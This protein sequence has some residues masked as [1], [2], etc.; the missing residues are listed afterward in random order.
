MQ[1]TLCLLAALAFTA[2]GV[3]MKYADGLRHLPA[4][5]AYLALFVAGAA[6]QSYA[7]RGAELGGT[8]ILV[9][10]AEALFAFGFGMFF[11]GEAVTVAKAAAMVLIVSGIAL[12]RIR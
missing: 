6:C 4:S 9:L 8:Y 11:F 5:A 7:L 10:G 1:L 12:L 3:L 2:G